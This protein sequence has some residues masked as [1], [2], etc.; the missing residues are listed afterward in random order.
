MTGS[1]DAEGVPIHIAAS[2]QHGWTG[3]NIFAHSFMNKTYWRYNGNIVIG[4][5]LC[6]KQC[7]DAAEVVYMAVGKY[8]TGD[9]NR[10][11][12][13]FGKV[14]GNAAGFEGGEGDLL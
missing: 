7:Q 3:N 9:I 13:L 14:H 2:T 5:L 11:E 12:V 8:H 6:I 4:D 1:R 10:T